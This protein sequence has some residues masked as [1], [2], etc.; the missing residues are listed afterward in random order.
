M[1][2]TANSPNF[3]HALQMFYVCM[4]LKKKKGEGGEANIENEKKNNIVEIIN[5]F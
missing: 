2:I 3:L 1:I 5:F 4:L